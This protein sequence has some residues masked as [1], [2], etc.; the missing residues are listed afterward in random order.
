[1][2]YASGKHAWFICDIC[3]FRYPYKTARGNWENFRVCNE[4]YEPKH[5][6]LDPPSIGADAEQLWRPRPDVA[7]PRA[8]L[9]VVTTTDPSTAVID[10]TTSPSGTRTMTFTDDPI[11]SKFEGEVGTGSVGDVEVTT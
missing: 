4:C 6:Q 9:G 2:A 11:G 10:N 1:M 8:G 5:P 3:S 7:L